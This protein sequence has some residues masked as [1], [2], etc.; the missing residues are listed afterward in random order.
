MRVAH[1]DARVLHI[2]AREIPASAGFATKAAAGCRSKPLHLERDSDTSEPGHFSRWRRSRADV[3]ILA[4][5]TIAD[6]ESPQ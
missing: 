1:D 2:S 4:T 6:S 3:E 5:I